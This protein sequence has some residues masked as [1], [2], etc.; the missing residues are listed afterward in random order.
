M[1]VRKSHPQPQGNLQLVCKNHVVFVSVDL[2]VYLSGQEY[3][4]A[5]EHLVS[6]N[7]LS[8]VRSSSNPTNS[9]AV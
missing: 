9:A 5:S 4:N 2:R 1:N 8:F 7:H 3:P 6:C